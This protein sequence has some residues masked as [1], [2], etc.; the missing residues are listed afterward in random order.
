MTEA[1]VEAIAAVRKLK[2]EVSKLD[3]KSQLAARAR[4]LLNHGARA[5][6]QRRRDME[7]LRDAA[8]GEVKNLAEP[9]IHLL[10]LAEH[11]FSVEASTSL[12]S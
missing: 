9:A 2:S 6:A 4:K 1:I 3:P 7:R 12:I 8:D 10:L 11:E 5:L